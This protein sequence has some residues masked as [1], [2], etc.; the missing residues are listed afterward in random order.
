M[1]I[2]KSYKDSGVRGTLFKFLINFLSISIALYL[3]D[4]D[5]CI[6]DVH[7]PRSTS[8][9]IKMPPVMVQRPISPQ[10][11]GSKTSSKSSVV[12]RPKISLSIPKIKLPSIPKISLPSIPKISLPSVP[13]ISL[14][15]IPK[16]NLPSVPKIQPPKIVS[17]AKST[18]SKGLSN[19]RG[20][21][22]V[23]EDFVEINNFI[24]KFNRINAKSTVNKGMSN[25]R[26]NED[27]IQINSFV[28]KFNRIDSKPKNIQYN[29]IILQS[30]VIC[31][32]LP[33]LPYFIVKLPI[34][35]KIVSKVGNIS[36]HIAF[37]LDGFIRL[38][39]VM[40]VYSLIN[41]YNGKTKDK[42][43]NKKFKK[44]NAIYVLIMSII[45][46]LI[47]SNK[48]DLIPYNKSELNPE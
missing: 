35:K 12:I 47:L 1:I 19:I 8:Q 42:S 39:T 45:F 6:L 17:N 9:D 13:K 23:N 41:M 21:F 43:C 16:V 46:N 30:A 18:V 37:L 29:K 2:E 33:I 31:A 38:L 14:P 5:M 3:R 7:K 22:R 4:V 32:A 44:N 26:V 10:P 34:L 11:S 25:I 24:K 20:K 48:A 27:F 36:P 40:F 15:S 28:K